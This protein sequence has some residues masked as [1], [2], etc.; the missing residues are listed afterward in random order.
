MQKEAKVSQLTVTSTAF[1][2]EGSIPS[3]FTCDGDDVSPPLAWSGAPASAHSYALVMD[4]PDA[5][6]GTFVHWVAWNIGAIELAEGVEKGASLA[7]G[8]RQG[9]NSWSK[10][11]Y[12]GPCPPS[13]TH[14]YF[15]KVYALDR[16]LELEAKTD[17]KALAA[18]MSGH[19]VAQGE[20]MGRYSRKR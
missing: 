10:A 20:L 14:R 4:D 16:K 5:P 12:G 18:A 11:G 9:Q 7:N 19:I 15:F 1:T 6:S 13:G 17:A 8:M 3:R 2:S